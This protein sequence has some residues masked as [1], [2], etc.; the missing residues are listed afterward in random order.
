MGFIYK[1]KSPR[2][3]IYIGMTTNLELRMNYYRRLK[4]KSQTKI[5]NSLKK[6]GW[7]NHSF[8]VILKTDNPVEAEIKLIEYYNSFNNGLNLTSGGDHPNMSEETK[9]KM[10]LVKKG[11][12]SPRKGVKLSKD[13]KSKISKFFKNRPSP[14]RKVVVETTEQ[15]EIRE[16]KSMTE[17]SIYHKVSLSTINYNVNHPNRI[18]NN[19]KWMYKNYQDA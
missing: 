14:N 13:T 18:Y 16:W 7:E 5:Y 3:R 19:S 6:Y 2:G 1:I 4:C 12:V 9:K 15:G 10:S 17:A 11:K 8:E